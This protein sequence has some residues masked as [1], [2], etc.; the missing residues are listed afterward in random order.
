MDL[1]LFVFL[2]YRPTVFT[3]GWTLFCV[4]LFVVTEDLLHLI[5]DVVFGREEIGYKQSQLMWRG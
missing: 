1:L 3:V 4:F 2:K 5:R